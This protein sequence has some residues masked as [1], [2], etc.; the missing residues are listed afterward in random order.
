MVVNPR[1]VLQTAMFEVTQSYGDSVRVPSDVCKIMQVKEAQRESW[2]NEQLVLDRR[3]W[4]FGE[5]LVPSVDEVLQ[6]LGIQTSPWE[7]VVL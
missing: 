7:R 6:K 2:T 3:L 4:E 5:Y 1:L